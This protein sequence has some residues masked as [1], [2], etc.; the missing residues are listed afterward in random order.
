MARLLADHAGAVVEPL[1]ANGGRRHPQFLDLDPALAL[2]LGGMVEPEKLRAVATV[3]VVEVSEADDV[4]VVALSGT[5]VGLQLGRQVDALV[6]RI[7]GFAHIGIVEEHLP[8]VGEIDAGAVGIAEG[9]EGQSRSSL[10]RL[11]VPEGRWGGWP[12][13]LGFGSGIGEALR[14]ESA[15]GMRGEDVEAIECCQYKH[16]IMMMLFVIHTICLRD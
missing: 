13:P 5:Q 12:S 11:L 2:V 7:V 14:L 16:L 3:I 1:L 15:G 8:A 4:E 10:P 6:G 9:M